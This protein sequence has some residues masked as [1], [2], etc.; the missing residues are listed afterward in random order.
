LQIRI[1]ELIA[2]KAA[3]N[4]AVKLYNLPPLPASLR[5]VDEIK[6][7]TQIAGVKKE[8]ERLSLQKYALI[9]ACTRQTQTLVASTKMQR[10]H[11]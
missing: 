9:Q 6:K 3:I 8:L 7:Y 10:Q 1:D 2:L 11:L 4:Q 5:L